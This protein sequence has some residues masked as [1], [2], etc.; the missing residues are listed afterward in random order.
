ML[1]LMSKITRGK[2]AKSALKGMGK[3]LSSIPGV[4]QISMALGATKAVQGLKE[5]FM[6]GQIK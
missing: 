4:K 6:P 2:L 3:A 1:S 5:I